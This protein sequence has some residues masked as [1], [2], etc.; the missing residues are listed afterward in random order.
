M[1][2]LLN[3]MI[4]LLDLNYPIVANSHF[5][6]NQ[7]D[8]SHIHV[9]QTGYRIPKFEMEHL[10]KASRTLLRILLKLYIKVPQSSC[11]DV[12][13]LKEGIMSLTKSH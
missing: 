12:L 5:V 8:F 1:E 10:I 2:H 7:T 9:L 6:K 3:K 13:I 4:I 11:C